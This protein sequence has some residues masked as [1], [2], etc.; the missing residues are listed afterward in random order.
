[1]IHHLSIAAQDPRRVAGVIAELWRGRAQP[2][3][4]VG[5][6]SWVAIA[7][8]ARNTTIEVYPFGCELQPV[9]GDADAHAV[10]NPRPPAFTAT[11]AAVAS[12]LGEAEVFAIARREAWEAKYRKRGGLFGVIELWLENRV[13]IEVLTAEMQAEYVSIRIPGGPAP[14]AS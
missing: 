7:G 3:P 4:P 11:H 1:M 14:P 2:F 12:P 8:D 5:E 10:V 9:E 13:L 6:G